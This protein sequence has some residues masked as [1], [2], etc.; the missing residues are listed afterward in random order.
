MRMDSIHRHCWTAVFLSM[1][2][3]S[4]AF[5]QGSAGSGAK[6][7]PRYLVDIPT[8]GMMPKGNFAVDAD[9]YQDGGLLLGFS[10]GILDRLSLG[11]SY[12]GSSLIGSGT[13]VMNEIPGMNVKVRVLEENVALPAFV[14]GFDSQGRDGYNRSLSRYIVKSPGFYGA[15]SKNYT[16]LGF[17]SFHAGANYSLERADGGNAVN[18]FAG[19]EKTVGPFISAVMEYSL[20]ANDGN[21]GTIG[22][23]KGYFNVGL[24][25]SLGGGLTLGVNLK[26]LARNNPEVTIGNRTVRIE[27]IRPF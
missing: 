19:V 14:I 17:L 12:G 1:V 5:S 3:V 11:I 27:Y 13:P 9:F 18:V 10:V 6:L 26:D 21:A 4:P 15:I 16:C 23:G 24:R 2:L 22:N 7:E 20:G 25:C 8:A